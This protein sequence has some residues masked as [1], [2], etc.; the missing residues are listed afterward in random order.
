MPIN[1]IDSTGA[2]FDRTYEGLKHSPSGEASF[3]LSAFDR[4]YEG[5]KRPRGQRWA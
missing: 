5:L 1:I 2:T 4:T 3:P